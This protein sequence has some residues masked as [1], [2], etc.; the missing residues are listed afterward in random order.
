MERGFDL[1]DEDDTND[2]RIWYKKM[3]KLND[4]NDKK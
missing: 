3:I 2:L 4:A 1:A